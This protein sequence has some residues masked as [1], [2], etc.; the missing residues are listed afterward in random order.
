MIKRYMKKIVT[1]MMLIAIIM[2]PYSLNVVEGADTNLDVTLEKNR[3]QIADFAEKFVSNSGSRCIYNA[4]KRGKTYRG[5]LPSSS[6]PHYYF[7]CVGW[8]SFAVNRAI[9]ITYSEC[10]SGIGGF[11][12]PQKGVKDTDHFKKISIS[13]A[14]R[15]DI[16]VAPSAPHV[17]IYLGGNQVV[18]MWS[19]GLAKRE[20]SGWTMTHWNKCTFTY[21]ATLISLDGQN[22]GTLPDGSEITPPDLE[23]LSGA[24]GYEYSGMPSDVVVGGSY[25]VSYYIDKISELF[26][27]IIGIMLNAIKSIP[28]SIT[29][30]LQ[31]IITNSLDSISGSNATSDSNAIGDS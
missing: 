11:V 10:E 9:G 19:A 7:D 12:T 2:S 5:K 27:Y 3:N 15:G 26:N 8:V 20:L 29:E 30:R 24:G 21:A 17:A 18:D 25:S 16:L 4:R 31:S 22:F 1:I 23:S 6:D 13:A 14:K 28:V